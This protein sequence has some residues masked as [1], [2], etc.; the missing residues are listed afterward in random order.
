MYILFNKK[1]KWHTSLLLFY[2]QFNVTGFVPYRAFCKKKHLGLLL[3]RKKNLGLNIH[4]FPPLKKN[5]GLNM[6]KGLNI[7]DVKNKINK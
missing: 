4:D 2:A 3:Y 1:I 5:L 7:S 6:E